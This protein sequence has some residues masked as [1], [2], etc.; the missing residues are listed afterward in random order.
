MKTTE[1]LN[2]L[3]EMFGEK[4][5]AADFAKAYECRA[6][7]RRLTKP[8]VT[9]EIDSESVK[10]GSEELRLCFKIFLPESVSADAAEE[11]FA[12]MCTLA[13]QNYTGF[14]AISRGGA[15]VDNTVGLLTVECA[16][17]FTQQSADGLAQGVR[18]VLG[19]REYRVMGCKT[20]VAQGGSNLVA[21]GESVPFAVLNESTE[22]T[23]ELEGI[24]VLGLERLAA[25]TAEL[26]EAS[27]VIYRGCRWKTLNDVL[28]KAVFVSSERVCEE[29]ENGER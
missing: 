14:S 19:G 7:Q 28:N 25:F 12:E 26:G 11:I 9:G 4:I 27:P 5:T 20:S 24:E 1:L 10:S 6:A 21:I 17:S 13:A 2:E 23:V 16:L 22:Y 8:L 29:V 18:A 15:A 3:L